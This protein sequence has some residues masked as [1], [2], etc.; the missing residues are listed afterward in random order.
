[1]PPAR[2]LRIVRGLYSTTLA[3]ATFDASA[4]Y[5]SPSHLLPLQIANNPLLTTPCATSYLS[6]RPFS[7]LYHILR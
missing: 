1:M 3:N 2:A 7:S 5:T 4:C 6:S